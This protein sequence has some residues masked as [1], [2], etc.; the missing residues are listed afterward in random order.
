MVILS[1][2]KI[3]VLQNSV[4]CHSE[5]SEESHKL[6]RNKGFFVASLLRMTTQANFAEVWN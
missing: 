2:N 6:F 3:R 5:R 4:D 1:F